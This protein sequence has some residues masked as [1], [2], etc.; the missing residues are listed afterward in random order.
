MLNK[1]RWVYKENIHDLNLINDICDTFDISPVLAEI[2]LNRNMTKEDINDYL[3]THKTQFLDPFGLKDMDIACECIKKHIK[4][5][6]K[7]AIYGDYDVDGITATFILVD[8]FRSI[9]VDVI[10]Y[11]PDRAIDGYGLNNGAIDKLKS[12]NI[13]LIITVDVGITAIDEVEYAKSLGLDIVITDHHTPLDTLPQANA[14]IDP[15]RKDDTYKNPNLAGVGV[16]YKLAYALSDL[17]EEIMQ[18]YSH[19]A[20][21]GTIAD[22][23]SLIGENR[24][25]AKYGLKK[26]STISNYGLDALINV[27]SIDKE[28]I[29]SG[30]IS[31]SLAPRLNAA[32]RI[33]S[34]STAVELLLCDNASDAEILSDKLD[35][36]NKSRQDEELKIL[37]EALEIIDNKKLYKNNVIIVAKENWHHGIIGIVSSK[38]TEK[39]YKP[40]AVL[41]IN[42]DGTCK[43]SGRSIPGFNFFDAL[44][45]CQDDLIKFGGH[46]LAAG[47]SLLESNI[48]KFD[49][50]INK[51]SDGIINDDL[52]T[53]KI[54]IDYDITSDDINLNLANDIK[55][56]EPFGIGN[57]TPVFSIKDL[58]IENIRIHKSGKHAFLTLNNKNKRFDSPAFNIVEC[59]KQYGYNDKINVAGTININYYKGDTLAQFITKDVNSHKDS[60]INIDNLRKIFIIIK[61]QIENKN[62]LIKLN[63][64]SKNLF[65]KQNLYYSTKRLKAV[66][67]IFTELKLI[68]TYY[69]NDSVKIEKGDNF[70]YKCDIYKSELFSKICEDDILINTSC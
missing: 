28:T 62:N 16:S 59:I 13:D 26:L 36:E 24:F 27:C 66:L 68:S 47:F 39:Y 63:D 6:S 70:N 38:I 33:E 58:K 57:K 31:F 21:I 60:L 32:G 64:L 67:D 17:N 22:M 10:Y 5:K 15:K 8:Y 12:H 30:N 53:Q 43:A 25:I 18:K 37:N 56:M 29:T 19:I 50:N 65:T 11:I 1:K 40:S 2:L 49:H 51:Y 44:Q 42:P 55:K 54:H 48:S 61:T 3:N 4:N 9:G 45:H 35:N 14:V 7:I 34:A 23:V 20:C 46:E 52:L 41:S 69:L